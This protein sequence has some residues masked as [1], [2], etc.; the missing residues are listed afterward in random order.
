[1]RH[2]LT[3]DIRQFV[4]PEHCTYDALTSALREANMF[5]D[6]AKLLVLKSC[7]FVTDD[8]SVDQ[9]SHG[10]KLILF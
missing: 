6:T 7:A 1:M 3:K 10:D 8:D 9:L 2:E 4:L 5:H